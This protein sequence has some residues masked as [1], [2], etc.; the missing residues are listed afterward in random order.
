MEKCLFTLML[1]LSLSAC[2]SAQHQSEL[3]PKVGMA[4]P[5]SQYCTDQ[6][7]TL[8]IQ[9]EAGGQVGYC[10]LSSGVVVEEWKFFKD[11]QKNCIPES[12]ETLIGK[13]KLSDQD[14][15]QISHAQIVRRVQPGQAVTMDFREDR[16]TVMIDPISNKITQA[17]CG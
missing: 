9:N 13:S 6:G 5:A 16:I 11:N 12:A 8:K 1:A 3:H 4:N 17:S 7:G 14:I 10:H 2:S 15:Q